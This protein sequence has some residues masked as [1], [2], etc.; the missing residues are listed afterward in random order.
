MRIV[1]LIRG[2]SNGGLERRTVNLVNKLSEN[3]L[4]FIILMT[5]HTQENE[6]EL[7]KKV[8]RISL[9]NGN[10]LYDTVKLLEFV[11]REKFDIIVGMGIYANWLVCLIRLISKNKVVVVEAN[12]PKHDSLRYYSRIL[13]KLLYWR[14]D[15]YIFQTE[16]ERN[17]YSKNIQ[18]KSIII[19]NPVKDLLP[20]RCQDVKKEII[21]V[22]RLMPQKN[23]T[24]LIKAFDVVH[25]KNPEYLLRIFGNGIEE[26]KLKNLIIKLGLEKYV[27]LEGF[28]IDVHEKIKNSDIFVMTSNYEGMPNA[29][30]EAMAMGFPVISTDCG[31]GGPRELINN[32]VNGILVPVGDEFFLADKMDW[33]INNIEEKENL[34][35]HAVSI[36]DSHSQGVICK[37]WEEYLEGLLLGGLKNVQM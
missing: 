33:L 20:L 4:H 22:G 11:V 30:M 26:D 10:L 36:R 16:E 3:N 35:S 24:M 18:K 9:L 1:F 12:D 5:D 17:F 32:N 2:I 34:A 19:H 37:L 28:C 23:Y 13:R 29:L 31:G 7:S 6:Y 25:K 27:S 15:G 8:H 14:A 21:A